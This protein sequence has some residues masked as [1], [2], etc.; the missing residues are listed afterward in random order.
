MTTFEKIVSETVETSNVEDRLV[1]NFLFEGSDFSVV[2]R[3]C[4]FRHLKYNKVVDNGYFG[5]ADTR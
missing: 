1:D 3:I 5:I 2:K 4:F